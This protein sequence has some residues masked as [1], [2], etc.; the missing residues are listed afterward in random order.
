LKLAAC[1]LRLGTF[2]LGLA[3]EACSLQLGAWTFEG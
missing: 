3:L 1:R 2:S